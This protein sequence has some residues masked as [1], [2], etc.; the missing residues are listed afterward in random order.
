[1]SSSKTILIAPNLAQSFDLKM[2]D[3]FSQALERVGF[4]SIPCTK[5]IEDQLLNDI[6]KETNA[7]V[8]IRVNRPPP[9]IVGRAN[10]FRHFSWIQDNTPDVDWCFDRLVTDDLVFTIGSRE[11]LGVAV[12]DK[13]YGGVLT[14]YID[15]S[16]FSQFERPVPEDIDLNL[17]GYIPAYNCGRFS[18]GL[19]EAPSNVRIGE[20]NLKQWKDAFRQLVRWENQETPLFADQMKEQLRLELLFEKYSIE[21]LFACYL[22]EPLT[23][24]LPCQNTLKSLK[25][26]YQ[27]LGLNF[28]SQ[29]AG[30]LIN[31]MPRFLDRYALAS[32]ASKL[33]ITMQIYGTNWS[34][35]CEF[36]KFT[37]NPITL[38]EAYE[39]FAKSR[40]TLQN[41]THGI[42][43]HYRTLSAMASGGLI[44]THG[45][46][47]DKCAGGM[48]HQFEAGVHYVEFDRYNYED[49]LLDWLTRDAD[50]I[51]IKKEARRFAIEK[52]NWDEGVQQFLVKADLNPNRVNYV[53]D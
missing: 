43:I 48:K 51:R 13:Y 4:N 37:R 14:T 21:E 11:A 6:V 33:N 35:Y 49:V 26:F 8:V 38:E 40:I 9:D 19:D 3:G 41:N 45:S 15:P 28:S 47:H 18:A 7:S 46:P 52:F 44:L 2:V 36:S 22:Y 34:D 5:P 24:S 20:F 42:G 23:G 29:R 1:M 30:Y 32:R 12:P 31:A 10:K 25:G 16:D 27:E 50:R 53:N 39:V 17:V